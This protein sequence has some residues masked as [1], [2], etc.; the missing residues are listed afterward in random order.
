MTKSEIMRSVSETGL[1]AT[2][3]R[4]DAP[5]HTAGRTVTRVDLVEAVYRRIGLSRKESAILVQ[6]VLDELAGALIAG[7]P[8]KLSTFGRFFV[9]SKSER[10]GRNPRTGV[11]VPITPRRVMVF[12]PSNVLRARINGLAIADEEVD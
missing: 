6:L 3:H 8:V 4:D 11:E 9:R 7:E 12:K 2:E 5:Q 10:I 1:F